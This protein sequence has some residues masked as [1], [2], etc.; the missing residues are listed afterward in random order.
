MRQEGGS[1]MGSEVGGRQKMGGRQERWERGSKMSVRR[2]GAER[3]GR[4]QCTHSGLKN[5]S[6]EERLD[7]V[8][9]VETVHTVHPKHSLLHAQQILS[10]LRI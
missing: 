1:E 7:D 4:T 6:A 10:Q 8:R 3:R 5:L 2:E 9:A